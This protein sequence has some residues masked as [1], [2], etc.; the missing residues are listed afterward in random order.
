MGQEE[1]SASQHHP[2]AQPCK[3]VYLHSRNPHH[4]EQS[5]DMG[6]ETL[7]LGLAPG[8]TLCILKSCWYHLERNRSRRSVQAF[9]QHA[10]CPDKH[11]NSWTACIFTWLIHPIDG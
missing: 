10:I 3:I 6:L 5:Q 8:Q 4:V 7:L 11:A 2:A 9:F 1:L